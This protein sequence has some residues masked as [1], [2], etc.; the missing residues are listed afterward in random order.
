[1]ILLILYSILLLFLDRD[2]AMEQCLKALA[3][4]YQTMI[5]SLFP[6]MLFSSILIDTG[7]AQRIGSVLYKTVLRPFQLSES[8][9]YALFMGFLCGFP[10][11]ANTV[12]QLKQN[13][14]LSEK[15]AEYLLAFNNCIGPLYIYNFVCRIFYSHAL[16]EYMAGLYG[17]ALLYGLLLRYTM[18]RG[19]RFRQ[20]S[21]TVSSRDVPACSVIDAVYQSI[22][23]SGQS[24]LLLGGYIVLFQLFFVV[25]KHFLL[26]INLQADYLY[27][28]IEISGGLFKQTAQTPLPLLLFW[29]HFGG[30]CCMIQTY[31]FIKPAGLSLKR[32]LLHKLVQAFLASLLAFFLFP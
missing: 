26:S 16:W 17:V 24:I 4:W 19:F 22:P 3:L 10:M 29:L 15:E 2:G 31:S 5:P 8:G 1:M 18:Y 20:E 12:S 30:L 28:L 21:H 32:Y 11:G 7:F 9:A 6:M 25:L 14:S 13:H 23:K 27:P